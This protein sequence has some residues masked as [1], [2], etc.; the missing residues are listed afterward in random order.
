M[1]DAKEIKR[2]LGSEM[3]FT[4][5]YLEIQEHRFKER[6]KWE[7]I[8]GPEV[9]PKFEVPKMC[10]HTYVENAVKHGF[11][12]I[13]RGGLLTIKIS[14]LKYGIFI[15]ITDN[16]IGRKASS[17]YKDSTGNGLKIMKEFYRLFEKYHGYKIQVNSSDLN[18][19]LSVQSGTKV[20]L[21]IQKRQD[22]SIGRNAIV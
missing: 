9:N 6:F 17:E 11:R 15:Q 13:E 19:G 7:F 10:I 21:I 12:D 22:L 14:A 18:E 20:E 4:R 5:N 8:I 3:D 1:D 2:P 16:G